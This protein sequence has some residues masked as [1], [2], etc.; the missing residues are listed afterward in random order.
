METQERT[1]PIVAGSSTGPEKV[2]IRDN[3]SLAKSVMVQIPAGP[4]KSALYPKVK[5]RVF[6]S[7]GSVESQIGQKFSGLC[8]HDHVL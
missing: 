5:I 8:S 1:L 7:S 6:E 3:K 4:R 2:N